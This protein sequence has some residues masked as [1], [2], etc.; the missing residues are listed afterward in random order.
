MQQHDYSMQQHMTRLAQHVSKTASM[1]DVIELTKQESRP[2]SKHA[3]TAVHIGYA[4]G[5]LSCL[6]NCLMRLLLSLT[7]QVHLAHAPS[8]TQSSQ[9]FSGYPMDV[10]HPHGSAHSKLNANAAKQCLDLR[11]HGVQTARDRQH[12]GIS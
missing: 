8:E 5:C 12:F 2:A 3:S 4:P 6:Q 10:Q 1:K 7:L 11:P 9:P